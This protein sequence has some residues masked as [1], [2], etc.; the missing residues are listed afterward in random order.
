MGKA[1]GWKSWLGTC[2]CSTM[3]LAPGVSLTGLG[4]GSGSDEEGKEGE[5]R[6]ASEAEDD[7]DSESDEDELLASFRRKRLQFERKM[8]EREDQERGRPHCCF[9]WMV[10]FKY[11]QRETRVA[12]ISCLANSL[13]DNGVRRPR[14]I[15]GPKI[16]ANVPPKGPC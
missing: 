9:L 2:V 7:E 14:Q 6:Q 1:L 10:V 13:Q 15:R 16:Q 4:Y 5:G 3:L 11:T 8:K 12:W